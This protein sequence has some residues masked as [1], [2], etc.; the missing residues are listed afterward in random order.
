MSHLSIDLHQS[1]T[2]A[3]RARLLSGLHSIEF[4]TQQ[5]RVSVLQ[6]SQPKA[7]DRECRAGIQS[8]VRGVQTRRAGRRLDRGG[9]R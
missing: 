7:I 3:L 2:V 6:A 5:T 8:H 4:S 1:G 9:V